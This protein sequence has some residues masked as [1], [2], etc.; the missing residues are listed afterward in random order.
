M[1]HIY[2]R[3]KSPLSGKRAPAF[4]LRLLYVARI[5]CVEERLS[6]GRFSSPF[7]SIF[8]IVDLSAFLLYILQYMDQPAVPSSWT[9]SPFLAAKELV[10]NI[11]EKRALSTKKGSPGTFSKFQ[12]RA[13]PLMRLLLLCLFPLNSQLP[14][15]EWHFSI[16][17]SKKVHLESSRGAQQSPLTFTS[18]LFSLSVMA[19]TITYSRMHISISKGQF[20]YFLHIIKVSN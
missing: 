12:G 15:Q 20:S 2:P 9:T 3:Q 8:S 7:F 14:C 4:S 1:V 6:K 13:E 16:A 5:P 18:P 10:A 19:P 17:S 11:Q